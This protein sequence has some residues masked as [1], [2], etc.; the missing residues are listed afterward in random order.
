MSKLRK[1]IK[2]ISAIIKKPSLLNLVFYDDQAWGDRV[3][4]EHNMKPSL[5]VVDIQNFLTEGT[6]TLETFAFLGGG[7]LPTDLILLK[8][9]SKK[10]PN[11][12]Y[13]EIGT[14]RGESVV[15]VADTGASCYTL[16]LSNAELKALN[17]PDSY[18]DLHG[19]FSLKKENVNYLY[20]NSMDYDFAGLNKKFD[21]IFID[22]DHHYDFVK[23]DTK[24]VFEHLVHEKSI[25]VW[26]D[27]AYSP[28]KIRPEIL[29]G[30]LDGIPPEFKKNLYHVS[31][32]MCAIF[33]RQ[34]LESFP[35]DIPTVPDKK[36]RVR[37]D[38][39]NL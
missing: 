16:N 5:P 37:V 27:Y 12:Q 22:G 36:F 13:F 9:L 21:L 25:V 6:E 8:S 34:P 28:E 1:A 4:K 3:E 29:L 20:G 30:I 18:A 14:W 19:F 17:I 39:E 26:H 11:C 33:T 24:K 15:N 31:N 2:A 10:I 7:S 38:L 32:T 23:N 35:I